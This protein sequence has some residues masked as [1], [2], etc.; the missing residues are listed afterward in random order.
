MGKMLFEVHPL[1]PPAFTVA[2]LALA[3]FACYLPARR[4]TRVDPLETLRQEGVR[5]VGARSHEPV[6]ITLQYKTEA[7]CYAPGEVI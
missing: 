2:A 7:E 6:T 5:W 3:A 4:A 1:D